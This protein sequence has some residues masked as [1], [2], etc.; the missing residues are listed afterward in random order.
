[1]RKKIVSALAL[2]AFAVSGSVFAREFRAP[3]LGQGGPLRYDV[4]KKKDKWTL[5]FWSVGHSRSATKAF[6][7][8]GTDT[9][10]LAAL[11]FGKQDFKLSAAFGKDVTTQFSEHFNTNLDATVLTPRVTYDEKGMVLGGRFEYPIWQNKGRVGVRASVPFRTVRVERDNDAET[12]A[13][14][15]QRNFVRG[16]IAIN[17]KVPTTSP[18]LPGANQPIETKELTGLSNM[19]KVNFI[20]SLPFVSAGTL[21]GF[22]AKAPDGD[23]VVIAGQKYDDAP[24]ADYDHAYEDQTIPF[25]VVYNKDA[26]SLPEVKQRAVRLEDTII[27]NFGGG[28][29]EIDAGADTRH[30]A[31]KVIAVG[32]GATTAGN[33]IG[34]TA[35]FG[36]GPGI[37]NPGQFENLTELDPTAGN[38]DENKMYV[39]GTTHTFA[40]YKALFDDPDQGDH[41][42]LMTT[43]L[44]DGSMLNN[45]AVSDLDRRIDR[46]GKESTEQWLFKNN[47]E[48]MTHQRTGMGDAEVDAFYEHDF[49]ED[50]RG[51]VSLGLKLPTGGSSDYSGNPYKAN[52]LLGNGNHVEVKLGANVG[53]ATP[54]DWLNLKANASY[55]IVVQ[56]VEQ[57]PAAFKDASIYGIGPKVDA[58]VDWGYFCGSLDATMF[59]RKTD[60]LSTTI[61]YELFYKTED[62]VNFKTMKLKNNWFGQKHNGTNFE[63]F[64]HELD[65]KVAER[66]TERIAHR[67]RFES[68][69][70]AHKYMSV[71]AGGAFTFAG[72]NVP[73]END[74]H[75]GMN[76]RF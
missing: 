42:W 8:H 76:V 54:W 69:W 19:Y 55:S 60:D 46:F 9:Q 15:D 36:A 35:N 29:V 70:H 20:R 45:A 32:E 44:H 68:H 7:K 62:N 50:W 56:S 34:E 72:Q 59:H 18:G 39:F 57:R 43:N 6:M 33:L 53:W 5:N 13:A 37:A 61:G 63:D 73:K 23:Q 16:D 25:V 64:V 3:L 74:V 65:N 51:E 41:F 11:M 4:Y 47:F 28:D 30:L 27:Q 2:T 24:T 52:P 48:F 75:C 49:N 67:I 66:N 10:D 17:V 21:G 12:V 38:F 40:A 22:I 26:K 31:K 14:G 58:D 71:F 1:M